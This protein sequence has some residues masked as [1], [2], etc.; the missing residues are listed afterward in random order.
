MHQIR[1][2]NPY[3]TNQSFRRMLDKKYPIRYNQFTFKNQ[4]THA[5]L[6]V[7]FSIKED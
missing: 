5:I 2:V 6:S 1:V 7:V 4:L 3:K